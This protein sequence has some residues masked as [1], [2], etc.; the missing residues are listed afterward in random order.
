MLDKEFLDKV[1]N[2]IVSE[3]R[4]D[5]DKEEI[6]TP[7]FPIIHFTHRR[8]ILLFSILFSSSP[9]LSSHCKDVYGIKDDQEIEYISTK[10]ME[11]ITTIIEKKEL[12]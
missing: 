2:Q 1:V 11:E 6:Y 4:I 3:T 5:Y 12:C 10:Y 8:T 9:Y 7:Y